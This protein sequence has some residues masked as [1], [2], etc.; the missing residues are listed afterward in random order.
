MS[1]TRAPRRLRRSIMVT[2]L[3][4][5][6]VA[7]VGPNATAAPVQT[8]TEIHV[9]NLAATANGIG[10]VYDRLGL[11][12]LS[13]IL[14]T[15]FP[16]ATSSLENTPSSASR[17]APAE[18]GLVGA[19]N[20]VGPVLGVPPGLIPPFPLYADASYPTGPEKASVGGQV[21]EPGGEQTILGL[22]AGNAVA[23]EDF[24]S[25]TASFG[26]GSSPFALPAGARA[27]LD[28]LRATLQGLV[29]GAS[30]APIAGVEDAIFSI[31]G[32]DASVETERDGAALR[33]TASAR[34]AGVSLLGGIFSIGAIESVM[35]MEWPDPASPPTVRSQTDILDARM[36]GLPIRFTSEGFEFAGNVLP[37]PVEDLINQLIVEQ[38]GSFRLGEERSDETGAAVT[39][40]VFDFDGVL[41]ETPDGVPPIPLVT[42]ERDIVHLTMG[43]IAMK[44][45]SDVY[46]IPAVPTPVPATPSPAPPT[47]AGLPAPNAPAA[48]SLPAA[49]SPA[50]APP[51]GLVSTAPASSSNAPARYTEFIGAAAPTRL[52][53]MAGLLLPLA[54]A[55]WVVLAGARLG[56]FQTIPR[57]P[58]PPA[59]PT[60][61]GGHR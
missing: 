8:P 26:H 39:A 38:G 10:L 15:G 3:L 32:G 35:T 58:L 54:A 23:R 53:W 41:V 16:R 49:A 34:L 36:L 5:A 1:A 2:G 55:W 11:L 29:R 40:L 30:P 45:A 22:L 14:D 57:A 28:Q 9:Y 19:L 25:A 21:G 37:A 13:P 47:A 50:A 18:P 24:G 61:P 7:V 20:G 51:T 17:A 48:P 59:S 56:L 52:A 12:A 33:A 42:N 6:L 43:A 27:G 44:Y 46:A 4:G 31:T 60:T